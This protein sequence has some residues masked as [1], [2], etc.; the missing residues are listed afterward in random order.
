MSGNFGG[1][2]NKS[3]NVNDTSKAFST[4]RSLGF[5]GYINNATSMVYSS[6][7]KPLGKV[8]NGK[9]Q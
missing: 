8:I 3:K 2:S 7:G 1:S 6:T 4:I 9:L 5:I